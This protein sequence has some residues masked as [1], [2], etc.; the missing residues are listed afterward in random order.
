MTRKSKTVG[1]WV[2]ISLLCGSTG[3]AMAFDNSRA[4][5]VDRPSRRSVQLD[6][7]QE[8]VERWQSLIDKRKGEVGPSDQ[9]GNVQANAELF[10][11]Q[12]ELEAIKRDIA[13]VQ[14]LN[15]PG[16]PEEVAIK[17]RIEARA[18]VLDSQMQST[19]SLDKLAE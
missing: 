11:A 13:E 10:K 1:H 8:R 12:N 15:R 17:D 14:A 18:S 19:E 3:G 16:S 6:R 4:D 9:F 7:Y 2:L 5:T